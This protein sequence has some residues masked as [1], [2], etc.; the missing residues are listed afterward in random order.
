MNFINKYI[1]CFLTIIFILGVLDYVSAQDKPIKRVNNNKDYFDIEL[2]RDKAK[3]KGIAATEIEGYVQFL[4]QQHSSLKALAKKTHQHTPYEQALGDVQETV[5]YLKPNQP[6]SIGCPNMGFEQYNF[7]GWTGST[8]TVST[9]TGLPNYNQ[10]GASILNPAGNNISV[11]NTSNYQTIMSLPPVNAVGPSFNGY[12]SLATRLISGQHTSQIPVVSPFSFDPVSVRMNG[13]VSNY[14]ASRLKYITTTSSLNQRLSFSYA[15]V[16]QNPGAHTAGESPYFK[17]EVRN[18]A[19]NTILPG[20]T[21]YTFNPKTAVAADSLFTSSQQNGGEPVVYRKWQYYSVDLSSLP[22][23]TNVSINFEVGGCSLSGHW[24]YAYVDAEC[25]GIGT[26]YANMCSGSTFATLVAPN[27]F[28]AYQW[29]DPSNNIIPGANSQTLTVNP[30]TPGSIYSVQ[31][32]SPGG[33]AITQTVQVQLTTVS[34][35]NLNSTSSCA[36]GNSGSAL[37]QA[38]GSNGVYTYTWTRTSN[39]GAG[40]VVGNSSTVTGLAPGNYSVVVASTSCGQASANLSVGTSPAF[41]ASVNKQ[42]CGNV[43]FLP[44]PGGTNYKWFKGNVLIPPPLGTNDTLFINNAVSGDIYSVVYN[45][46]FGCKDSIIYNLSQTNGGNSFVSNIVDVCP[47]NSNGSAVINLSTTAP[48]PF[49]YQITSPSVGV[50][51]NTTTSA[52]SLTLTSLSAGTYTALIND[53]NCLYNNLITINSIP[54]NFTAT[55]NNTVLCF[56]TDTALINISIPQLPPPICGL[57]PISCTSPNTIQLFTSGPFTQNSASTYPT[58]YGNWYTYAKHQFLIRKAELN[59]A[60]IFAGKLS[61][62]AFNVL[63]MNSSISNYPNFSIKMGCTNLNNVPTPTTPFITGLQTVYSSSNQP[64]TTGWVTHNFNQS[65]LWDGNSNIIVEVCFGMN[66]IFNFSD[67]VTVE[68]KQMPYN[69]T[70]FNREDLIPICNGTQQATNPTLF[71]VANAINMV[72][73]MRFGYCG[74]SPP[75]SDYT[76]SVSANGSVTANNSNTSI[77]VVPTFTAPPLDNSTTI[78]TLTLTNP[79]GGC[80]GTQTVEVFYP[81]LSNTVTTNITNTTICQGDSVQ[82]AASGSFYINWFSVQSGT[83]TPLSNNDSIM[84]T[85]LTPGQSTYIVTGTS[86][87][88]SALADTKT[89]TVNVTPKANLVITPLLDGLKCLNSSYTINTNVNSGTSGNP[90]TP[91]TYAWTE[92]PN[93]NPAP[94]INNNSSYTTTA[95]T[96]ST[97][98]VTVNGDCAFA[99][100]DTVVVRNLVDDLSVSILNSSVTCP[101]TPFELNTTSTN[102]YQPYSFAWTID[103]NP[104]VIGNNNLLS[105]TSPNEQGNYTITFNVTDSCGYTRSATQVIVVLPPCSVEIPNV[106]TPNG[107]GVNETFKIKNIEL[108]PNTVVIIFDRWGRKIYESSNYQNDWKADGLSNGTFFYVIEVPNDKKYTGFISVFKDK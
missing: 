93:G 55:P 78:Y 26:P 92:L 100:S 5:I 53:G 90:A 31:M 22:A 65:Y 37:V 56:P 38:S 62:L 99:Q 101:N 68:L 70:L 19:T 11:L 47:G 32:I 40:T 105:Y 64:V 30:A 9:G 2:A 50:I 103:T 80:V 15:V 24:G 94:G 20:C 49:N 89:I 44:Q 72:P 10:T 29:R 84:V 6:Q 33:C 23:G 43:T 98:V 58:P 74:Y 35:I 61:S 48:A 1:S 17:V 95:S 12:D 14:R 75:T 36:G 67:N 96:T 71:A 91:F 76:L 79:V 57:D 83:Q 27:G 39:P 73:N 69:A 41:F 25:G 81:T 77:K 104:S 3:A 88:P 34:I 87:C 7:T 8:G 66:S 46:N 42:F 28:T 18:E 97:F 59:A 82:L 63:S 16:L 54:T 45:N 106:I 85:P 4:K 52:T 13:A 102:G 21:S 108:F 60:G 86:P 51:T 107:D